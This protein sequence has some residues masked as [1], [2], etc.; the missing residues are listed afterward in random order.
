MKGE[1]VMLPIWAKC[2]SSSSLVKGTEISLPTSHTSG[3]RRGQL[4]K[5]GCDAQGRRKSNQNTAEVSGPWSLG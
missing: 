5:E 4:E 1:V 3:S 2:V